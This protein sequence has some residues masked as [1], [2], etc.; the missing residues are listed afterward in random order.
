MQSKI[1]ISTSKIQKNW[2]LLNQKSSLKASAVVKANGYGFGMNKIAKSLVNQGCNFF[3]LAQIDEAIKLRKTLKNSKNI[4]L[5][6]FE[7]MVHKPID[8][9]K[10]DIIPILNNLNQL[11]K[12]VN[13]NIQSPNKILKGILNIDTGMNRLG[14]EEQEIINLK[15]HYKN[16]NSK[17]II[18][19][20]SHLSH[21]NIEQSN[22]NK[23]QLKKLITFSSLFKKIKLSLS[24]TNGIL[25]GK[26]F[27]LDQTRPGIGIF[28]LDA[29]GKE[30]IINNA[31]LQIPFI[32]KC[33]IIQIR[34][35]KKNQTISY[36]GITKLKKNSVIATIGIGY[37][38]GIFRIFKKNL[39]V[40]I[41]NFYC[42]V[43]GNITMDSLMIDITDLDENFLKVGDYIELLNPDNFSSILMQNPDL[44]IYE[45]FTH[46][47]DRI[48]KIYE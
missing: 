9:I 39:E 34:K 30:I 4:K 23:I 46:L 27:I 14:F 19:I 47:S 25:L 13:Y 32:L 11:N 45:I 44:N 10:N 16:I 31:K 43:M 1:I 17:N 15:S 7:G 5:A 48:V 21:S 26:K 24:N 35:V 18:F 38:D 20:M 8:Y 42:R 37:A 41:K 36:E 40:K 33:P 12:L 22:T 6:V 28:G 2:E 29:N 3:Y